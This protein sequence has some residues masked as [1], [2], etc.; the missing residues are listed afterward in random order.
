MKAVQRVIRILTLQTIVFND[1]IEKRKICN[2]PNPNVQTKINAD[3]QGD[4]GSLL[5]VDL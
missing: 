5:P 3:Y 4:P 1:P 2:K